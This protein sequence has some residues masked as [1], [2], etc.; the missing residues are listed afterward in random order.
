MTIQARVLLLARDAQWTER[1]GH[2]LEKL[3]WRTI[4]AFDKGAAVVA[5]SD[6]QIEAVLVEDNHPACSPELVLELR[7]ACAPRRLPVVQ[8]TQTERYDVPEGWDMV[9]SRDAHAQQV[10]LGLEHMVRANVAEEEYDL[11]CQTLSALGIP[12][13][14]IENNAPLSILSVGQPEPDFLGL[15]HTLRARG[16]DVFA[17]FTSYS[18]FDY[19]HDKSFDAVVLWGR[20]TVSEALSIASGMRRNTR[21]YHTPVFLRLQKPVELDL[22]DTFLRGVNDVSALGATEAEIADRVLRLARAFRRQVNIRKSLESLRHSAHMDKGTGLFT[23]DLF[24]AHLARLTKAASERNRPLSVCVLKISETP[25]IN[26]ARQRKALDRAMPQIGSMISRLVRAEDTA[27]RLSPEVFA[28]ALPAT[29]EGAARIVAERIS[30]VIGCTAFEAGTGKSPFVVEFD[31]GVAQILDN[32]P[33]AEALSRAAQ[34]ILQATT[35]Q[36]P[37]AAI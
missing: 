37:R 17:A 32:E 1:L 25:E 21:L 27:G 28:L 29:P 7:D 2:D 14:P 24:A 18:A 13:E 22:S 6:L 20:D 9:Y 26:Q 12:V 35:A 11:R 16:A 33:A 36:D 8:I 5:I 10:A 4:T 19:L 15:S 34:N 23:R 3:G 30:A 31:V